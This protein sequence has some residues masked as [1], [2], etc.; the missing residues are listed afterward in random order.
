[1]FENQKIILRRNNSNNLTKP[2][3]INISTQNE[4][5]I[6]NYTKKISADQSDKRQNAKYH[7]N[8]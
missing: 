4:K 1:M 6:P 5:L 2:Q 3:Q 8:C 7:K